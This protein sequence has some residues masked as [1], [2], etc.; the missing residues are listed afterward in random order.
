MSLTVISRVS[1]DWKCVRG[2]E[3]KE[4]LG[5]SWTAA[6]IPELHFLRALVPMCIFMVVWVGGL[7]VF[8]VHKD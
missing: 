3:A 7:V 8:F 4:V 1:T 6:H 2:E 5:S